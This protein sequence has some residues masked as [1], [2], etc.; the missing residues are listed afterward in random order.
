[1]RARLRLTTAGRCRRD[2]WTVERQIGFLAALARSGRVTEAAASV[3][4]SRES[5][6][7]LRARESGGLFAALWDAA[8]TPDAATEGHNRPLTDGLLARLLG[9]A[10]RRPNNGFVTVAR[11]VRLHRPD[12]RPRTL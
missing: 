8:L 6:H 4:M 1:M 5:A 3:G 2:G 10:F 9:N 11:P 7:R 12:D